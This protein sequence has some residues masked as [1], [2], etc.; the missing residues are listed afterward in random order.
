[1]M[2]ARRKVGHYPAEPRGIGLHDGSH[3]GNHINRMVDASE[4]GFFA[5]Y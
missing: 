5:A 3:R 1:M 2:E 4:I